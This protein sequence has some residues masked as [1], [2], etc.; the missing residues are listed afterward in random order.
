MWVGFCEKKDFTLSVTILDGS[1]VCSLSW[2][3][4][5]ATSELQRR[6]ARPSEPGGSTIEWISEQAEVPRLAGVR[7][8]SSGEI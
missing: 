8:D 7:E 1:S 3:G 5:P 2:F 6:F 4:G